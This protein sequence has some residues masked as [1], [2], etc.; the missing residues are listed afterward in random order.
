[1]ADS[2]KGDASAAKLLGV[3][4]SRVSQ[5]LSEGILYAFVSAGKSA[6]ACGQS[7]EAAG[8]SH[9][10]GEKVTPGPVPHGHGLPG[11]VRKV[12]PSRRVGVDRTQDR[13]DRH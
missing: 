4:R 5:R 6:A 2:V 13:F 1:M 7:D 3:D 8:G 12:R 11:R 9:R 10:Q